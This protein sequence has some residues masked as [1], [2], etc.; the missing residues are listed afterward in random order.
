M[1]FLVNFKFLILAVIY[2]I[3]FSQADAVKQ[4]NLF[5]NATQGLSHVKKAAQAEEINPEERVK[6]TVLYGQ[7]SY[8]HD[9]FHG[10]LTANGEVFSQN[11]MTAACNSLPLGTWIKIT[12]L[13]NNKSITLKTNDRLHPKTTRLVDLSRAAAKKLNFIHAGLTRVKVEVLDQDLY[14]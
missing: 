11:K 6:T 9:M 12:N 1:A 2:F 13:K 4:F 14:P 7:A 5:Q 3:T 8:Y 10:R